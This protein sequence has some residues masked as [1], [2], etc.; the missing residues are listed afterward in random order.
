MFRDNESFSAP[1]R[2]T[3]AET[4]EAL[5][6]RGA[7]KKLI[8]VADRYQ[9]RI[10]GAFYRHHDQ[11]LRNSPT[12][13]VERNPGNENEDLKTYLDTLGVA[14]IERLQVQ[15]EA[16][17]FLREERMR[18]ISKSPRDAEHIAHIDEE[19]RTKLGD[20]ETLIFP[21]LA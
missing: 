16:C 3:E 21:H 9:P 20:I 12:L 19:I 18:E 14:T 8:E 10:W 11:L 7:H 2:R 1:E 5:L 13:E 15:L 6:R 4:P 17:D